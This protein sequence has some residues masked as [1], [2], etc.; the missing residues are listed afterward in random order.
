[1]NPVQKVRS[2]IFLDSEGFD[3][4]KKVREFGKNGCKLD[5]SKGFF[6]I[7]SSAHFELTLFQVKFGLFE[8]FDEIQNLI[9]VK[10]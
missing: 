4:V 10:M 2:S 8:G 5:F 6:W 7:L 3:C 1:M 9:F